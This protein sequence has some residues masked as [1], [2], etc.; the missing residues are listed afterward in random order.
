MLNGFCH[1]E[2]SGF[3]LSDPDDFDQPLFGPFYPAGSLSPLQR[4]NYYF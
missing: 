4:F 3:F 1:L 2:V